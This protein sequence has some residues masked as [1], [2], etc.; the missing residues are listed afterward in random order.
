MTNGGRRCAWLLR[1]LHP[2]SY[3]IVGTE[4]QSHPT[5]YGLPGTESHLANSLRSTDAAKGPGALAVRPTM[6]LTVVRVAGP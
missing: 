4:S 6:T 2:D 3:S 5:A 1:R